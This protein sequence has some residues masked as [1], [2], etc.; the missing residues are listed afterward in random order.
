VN[1]DYSSGGYYASVIKIEEPMNQNAFAIYRGR[2]SDITENRS[3]TVESFSQLQGTDWNYNNTPKTFNITLDTRMLTDDG[4]L[5]LRE[6]VAFGEDSYL[7]RTVYIVANGT[8]AVLVSTAPY[9]IENVKGTVY[10]SDDGT[11]ILRRASVYNV[12][13]YMWDNCP[14]IT[15]NILKNT[16]AIENGSII[17][18]A[19]IKKGAVVRVIKKDKTSTGDA[20]IIL[21]E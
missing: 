9:G 3:F 18:P 16:I 12:S 8:N 17:D 4:V 7:R 1:R 6:F 11:I 5:N 14:D 20:Y 15:V 21:V 13:K 10:T 19:R 2:I